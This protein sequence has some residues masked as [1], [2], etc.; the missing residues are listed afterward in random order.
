MWISQKGMTQT[1]LIYQDRR[2]SAGLTRTRVPWRPLLVSGFLQTAEE[3]VLISDHRGGFPLF[4]DIQHT[5]GPVNKRLSFWGHDQLKWTKTENMLMRIGV[6]LLNK[7]VEHCRTL[8]MAS[9]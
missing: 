9:L 4:Q 1:H 7:L 2:C 6:S 5:K 3:A 8:E